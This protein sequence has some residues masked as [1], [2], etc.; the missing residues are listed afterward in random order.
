MDMELDQLVVWGVGDNDNIVRHKML[1]FEL[2]RRA[3]KAQVDAAAYTK[4]MAG[5]ALTSIVIALAAAVA[6]WIAAL[7]ISN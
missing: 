4:R 6:A 1:T 7:H 5:Y 3:T 2:Q